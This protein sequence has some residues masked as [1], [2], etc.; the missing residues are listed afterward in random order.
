MQQKSRIETKRCVMTKLLTSAGCLPKFAG[1]VQT[2][3]CS[4][5]DKLRH[6]MIKGES[7]FSLFQ[8]ALPALITGTLKDETDF[9]SCPMSRGVSIAF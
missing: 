3:L 5:C 4:R 2:S 7:S 1:V 8:P 9:I 6:Y